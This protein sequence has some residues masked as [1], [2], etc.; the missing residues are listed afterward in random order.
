M[1]MML[2]DQQVHALLVACRE[3][4]AQEIDC[5]EFLALMTEYAEARVEGRA[6]PARAGVEEHERLCMSCRE[7]CQALIELLRSEQGDT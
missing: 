4:R 7:E 5:D 6:P 3:T 2:R 1:P